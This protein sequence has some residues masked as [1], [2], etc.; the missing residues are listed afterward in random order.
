MWFL[1][2]IMGYML[3]FGLYIFLRKFIIDII[4]PRVR[5]RCEVHGS[6]LFV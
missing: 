3:K 6:V 2:L 1:L 4:M 5:M